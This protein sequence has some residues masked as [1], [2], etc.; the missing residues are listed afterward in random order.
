MQKRKDSS[1]YQ[2]GISLVPGDVLKD[3]NLSLDPVNDF[4]GPFIPAVNNEEHNDSFF[5][6]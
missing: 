5:P 2:S 6:V 3:R 1:V 4:K